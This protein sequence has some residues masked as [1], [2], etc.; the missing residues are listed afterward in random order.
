MQPDDRATGVSG[1]APERAVFR[2][3]GT[4]LV[5]T[6]LARG[7]WYPD[8]QHGSAMLGLLARAIDRH[9]SERPVQVARFTADMM[10]AAPMRAVETPCRTIRAGRSL[11]IVEATIEADGETFARATAVRFR[12]ASIDVGESA[13]RYAGT[14]VDLPPPDACLPLPGFDGGGDEPFHRAL[15]MR[16]P[17][18]AETPVMW[19]RMGCP[20]VAG[21]PLAP[22][23]RTAITADWTYSVPQMLEMMKSAS[24]AARRGFSAINPDTTVNLHRPMQGEWLCLDAHAFYGE[25][26]AGTAL[27]FLHDETGPVGHAS[28]CI[29]IRTADKAPAVVGELQGASPEPSPPRR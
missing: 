8:T 21:E 4:H 24:F 15:E 10:R 22:F 7:P 26:G 27:A 17:R 1:A 28:Q 14:A 29:L 20:L 2:A 3:D 12:M 9:P 19:F 23:V 25:V 11:E 5:P 18:G 6:G 13:P 16:R